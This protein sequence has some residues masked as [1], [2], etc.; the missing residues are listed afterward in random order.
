MNDGPNDQWQYQVRI[1]LSPRYAELARKDRNNAALSSLNTLLQRHGASLK[2]QFDA[3]A[4]YVA[5]AEREGTENYPLYR[6]TR[7]TIEN[8]AKQAKYLH[9]FT[10][11]VNGDEVYDKAIADALEL[12]LEEL[13]IRT[14][15]L[16]TEV[17]KLDTNPAH[18]PQPPSY[19][20][21]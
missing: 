4:D 10:L 12:D 8:P 19:G 21:S 18:N 3:F 7:E 13:A 9:A 2:C 16:I 6:W 14:S 15:D 1:R 17:R 5:E 11:Y 20:K